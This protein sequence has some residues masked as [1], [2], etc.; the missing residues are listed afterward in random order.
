MAHHRNALARVATRALPALASLLL[1][2]CAGTLFAVVNAGAPRDGVAPGPTVAFA[3]DRGLSLDVYRPHR[4]DGSAPM[5]VFFYGGSWQNGRRGRYAFA[6]RALAARGLVAV[7]PDYRLYPA[8]RFPAFMEDAA[9]TV[10]WAR[11]NAAA[12]GADPSR[13]YVMGHS[14]GAQ[15]AALLAT[16]ERWLAR[17]GLPAGALAGAIALSGPHDVQPEGYPDLEDLFGPPDRWPQ[18]RP[19]NFVDGGEPPF[20]L[21]HG[22]DDDTVWPSQSEALA[23]RLRAA[24]VPVDLRL[25]PGVGHVRPLLALRWPRLAP[26]LDDTLAFIAAH[27]GRP[28]TADRE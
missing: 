4:A 16:D 24:G 15:I 12:L 23:R 20:L 1:A 18:A 22:A 5:V 10:A 17:A 2:G 7:V 3:P 8:V 26:V 13:L 21:L 27:G 9:D 28:R 25:Y 14:A 6:G 11:A 19:V